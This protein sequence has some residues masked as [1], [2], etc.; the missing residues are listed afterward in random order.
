MAV[1]HIFGVKGI[2]VR[3]QRG[4]DNKTVIPGKAVPL[5]DIKSGMDGE[6]TNNGAARCA[7]VEVWPSAQMTILVSI[8][9][10]PGIGIV[11]VKF[12]SA[13]VYLEASE[14]RFDFLG[15]FWC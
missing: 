14:E 6:P 7:L 10:L 4:G 8:N 15:S 9:I 2:A 12:I 3:F 5:L 13:D 11:P 1:L